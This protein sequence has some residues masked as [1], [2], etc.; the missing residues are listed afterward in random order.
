MLPIEAVKIGSKLVRPLTRRLVPQCVVNIFL[1]FGITLSR[2][3]T[4]V[5]ARLPEPIVIV[6]KMLA[7]WILLPL[8]VLAFS[9]AP[10][11][12]KVIIGIILAHEAKK[13]FE[14][15]KP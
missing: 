7:A 14:R 5:Q 15:R 6:I 3:S 10:G 12:A 8:I 2:W 1:S 9:L 13:T 4:A 11:L